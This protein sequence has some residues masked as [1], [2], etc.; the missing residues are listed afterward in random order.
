MRCRDRC[1][2]ASK[3]T[4][5]RDLDCAPRTIQRAWRVLEA[6][7]RWEKLDRLPSG[8]HVKTCVWRL[9]HGERRLRVSQ[10]TTCRKASPSTSEGRYGAKTLNLRGGCTQTMNERKRKNQPA[11]FGESEVQDGRTCARGEISPQD[12]SL[13]EVRGDETAHDVVATLVD[14]CRTVGIPLSLR[15]RGIIAKHAKE[16]LQADFD[17]PTV[18]IAGLM[19][20]RRGEPWNMQHIA[21]D[22]VTARAGQRVTRREYERALEEEMILGGLNAGT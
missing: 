10:R 18:V 11:L 8:K 3:T 9:K 21:Q 4:L 13:P 1:C 16:L 5:A 14:A 17:Y 7:G 15:Y 20:I 6:S 2:F 19:S 12:G 22:F